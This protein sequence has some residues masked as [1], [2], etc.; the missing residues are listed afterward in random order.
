MSSHNNESVVFE[1]FEASPDS[2][3]VISSEGALQWDFPGSAVSISQTEFDNPSFQESLAAFLEQASTESIKRFAAHS[4][5]AGVSVIETRDAVDPSLITQML[6]TLLEANGCPSYPL[7]LRKRVRDDVCWDNADIPWR[8]CPYWLVLRVSIQRLLYLNYGSEAGRAYYKFLICLVLSRLLVDSLGHLSLELCTFLKVKLCRRLAKL[9]VDKTEAPSAVR[10]VYVKMFTA[11]GP[12][13]QQ[14]IQQATEKTKSA[15][16][17]FKNVIRRPVPSLPLRADDRDLQL[18][19]SNSLPYLQDI[20]QPSLRQEKNH[21]SFVRP[22]RPPADDTAKASMA[23]F[24]IFADRYFSLTDLEARIES[25]DMALPSSTKKCEKHCMFL[26][27]KIETY[28]DTVGNAYDSNPEQM[29]IFFLN[30]FELWISMDECATDVFPLLKD[31]HPGFHPQLLDVLQLPRLQDMRR[32]QRIQTYLHLRSTQC[33]SSNMTIFIGP[34]EGC[35]AARY[36]GESENGRKL[37]NLQRSI[38]IV[39]EKA[40]IS[41]EKEWMEASATYSAFTTQIF[42]TTCT[43]KRHDDGSHDIRGCTHCYAVRQRRRL[44]ICIH[45]NPLPSN[46]SSTNIVQKQAILFELGIPKA[47]ALYRDVTWRIR[48]TFGYPN[49]NLAAASPKVLLRAYSQLKLYMNSSAPKFSLAS[50]TKS[51]LDAHYKSFR[52]PIALFD[53]IRP[54]GLN[55]AYYD[56]RSRLWPKDLSEAPNFAHLCGTTVSAYMPNPVIYSTT[57]S[58]SDTDGPSSYE[59]IASQTHCPPELTVHEFMTYQSLS[60]GKTRRW[61]SMLVELG[62]SNLNFSVEATMLLFCQLALQAGPTGESDVLRA[63]HVVF[64]DNLFC[65]RLIDQIGQRIDGISANWRENYC[66]E[67]LLTLNLRLC[68]LGSG[69]IVEEGVRMIEKVRAVTL[70]WISLLRVE[71]RGAMEAD[72]AERAAGYALWAAL[73]CRRTYSIYADEDGSLDADTIRPF[74]EASIALQEVLVIDPVKLSPIPRKLL[75]RDLKMAC[76]MLSII[77]KSVEINPD[78][79]VS[80][81]NSV[82]PEIDN[83]PRRRYSDWQILSP[84][85]EYWIAST[86]EATEFTS[87]QVVHYHLLEGHLLVD[88][89]PLGRLPANIRDSEIIKELFGNQHLLTFPSALSGMTYMLTITMNGHQ[90]HFGFRKQKLLVRACVHNTVLEFIDRS[91]FGNGSDLDLPAPLVQDCVHWL[92]LRSGLLEL[93]RRPYIWKH[94]PGNWTLNLHTRRAHRRKASLVDP[95]SNLF[96]RVAG[97]FQHFEHH[98]MLTLFQPSHRNL[99]VEL[100]RLQL[101]FT[102][103]KRKLFRSPQLR[104]EIDPDQDAGTLYGLQSKIVLRDSLNP[105]QRS[106]IVPMGKLKYEKAG[107]HVAV[108]VENDG[109]YGKYMIDEVLGR[110]Q[111]PS[112]PLLLYSKAQFHA[113]TSFVLPDPLTGRTGT[114]EALHCLQS[115]CCQPWTPI[116]SHQLQ[117]LNGIAKLTP[118]RHYYPKN[119][120]RQQIVLWDPQLTISIQHDSYRPIIEAM[121]TKLERLSTF[122]FQKMEMPP[123]DPENVP[124]LRQ[125]SYSRRCLYERSGSYNRQ[126]KKSSDISYRARDRLLNFEGTRNV[127][128]TVTLLREQP[129]CICKTPELGRIFQRWPIIGGYDRTFESPLLSDRLHADLALEWGGLVNL[130][131]NSGSERIY[132]LMFQLGVIAFG[133]DVDMD[134]VR[135]L[136]AYFVCEDLKILDPPIYHRFTDF[137]LYQA[138]TL[139]SLMELIEQ[140]YESYNPQ[141]N[142]KRGKHSNAQQLRSTETAKELYEERRD[143]DGRNFASFLLCQWPCQEPT[144]EGLT[145]S[146]LEVEKVMDVVRPEWLRLFQNL[147]LSQHVTQVQKVLKLNQGKMR[148]ERPWILDKKQELFG[149]RCRGAEI[150]TLSQ[151]LLLKNGPT[152]ALHL[153]PKGSNAVLPNIASEQA[154]DVVNTILH[155]SVQD[156]TNEGVATSPFSREMNELGKILDKMSTSQSFVR[157][158]YGEDLKQSL[159]ALKTAKSPLG[160]PERPLSVGNLDLEIGK[161]RQ[162]IH[163]QYNE[164]HNAFTRGD[165]RF[166]WLREGNLWPC[167]TPL[168][169]LEQLR[170]T[171]NN[172]FGDHMKEDLTVYAVSITR[173]Q[174]L[175]RI[176]NATIKG[177]LHRLRE[178]QGNSGHGNWRPIEYPDWL[179]LEIDANILIRNE[180]VDVALSTISPASGSNSVLQMNMGQGK[181]CLAASF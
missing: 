7:M 20:L 171:S 77:C 90:I 121:F 48:T 54:L 114:E 3:S 50:T 70:G 2:E 87:Q 139:E 74:I 147:E 81:I 164:I 23:P 83:G 174:R 117:L 68:S 134:I 27:H 57:L 181:C 159:E 148:E 141:L 35:F 62:S 36:F 177:D 28:L 178:E 176:K 103:N 167:I 49:N 96:R 169:L 80:A 91:V 165:S 92:D 32:L 163:D 16:T 168:T 84:P 26:A 56:S 24:R 125:R 104:S 12:V 9:E 73:L 79:L 157:K 109:S 128:Q 154:K 99:T 75:I 42:S 115:G 76:K 64:R 133:K 14:T 10:H 29:S 146:N 5:K 156:R 44:R 78:S 6:M 11:V 110:L 120:K 102:V 15:W 93:R 98:H 66:M 149:F 53:V 8:R 61:F 58:T 143:N 65:E 155:P 119:L 67:M 21:G 162:A 142:L 39:S 17:A 34:V 138:P 145:V 106:I 111:C 60:S 88:R 100:K 89:K 95:R 175:L 137:R 47:F 152:S 124:Q 173:L 59:V 22:L 69:P 85:Y 33:T 161:S 130:C 132:H 4:R 135:I 72:A 180:Q 160:L 129:S 113:F 94:R 105:F 37:Q 126:Q 19:L 51:H 116:N 38:E 82:W 31:Y 63:V 179:L 166:L 18:C 97:I 45:E 55:V 123:S 151:D 140:C 13:F 122:T 131:R 41:K 107:I 101:D 108:R 30:L 144:V 118:K 170:S 112:E 86:V 71:I 136:I 52:L 172:V 40:R 153:S 46:D 158:Q 1:A 150:P 43:E 127:Y 25:R